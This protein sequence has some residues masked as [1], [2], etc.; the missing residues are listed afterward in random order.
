M[1]GCRVPSKD[2]FTAKHLTVL[3]LI[4]VALS[5]R[6]AEKTNGSEKGRALYERTADRALYER[7]AD[8]CTRDS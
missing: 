8:S 6:R 3:G 2:H 7:T 5:K 1:R 4:E